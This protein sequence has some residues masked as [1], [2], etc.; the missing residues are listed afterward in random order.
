[1]IYG[2]VQAADALNR[3]DWQ[4]AAVKAFWFVAD[5]M[6]SGDTLAHSWRAGK[7]GT[8]GLAEDY[9]NMARAALALYELTGHRPYFEK[10]VAWVET[11]NTKFWRMDIGGYASTPADGEPLDRAC[12]D[13]FGRRDAGGERHDDERAGAARSAYRRDA[14]TPS[15]SAC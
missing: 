1:M 12:T 7:T 11:L 14:F 9:A 2:L 10:A 3:V 4:A 15:A 5:T 8:H 13:G 6:G